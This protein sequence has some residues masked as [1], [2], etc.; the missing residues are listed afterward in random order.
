MKAHAH[1]K[2]GL[3]FTYGYMN[4]SMDGIKHGTEKVGTANV[5]AAGY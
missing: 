5:F 3:M 1:Q 2:G 4:M